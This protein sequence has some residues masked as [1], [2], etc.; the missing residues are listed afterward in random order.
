MV[1][2]SGRM[3]ARHQQT[4]LNVVSR[5]SCRKYY[6]IYEHVHSIIWSQYIFV[7][8]RCILESLAFIYFSNNG[9]KHWPISTRFGSLIM[10][11]DGRQQPESSSSLRDWEWFR[12]GRVI[13]IVQL[14]AERESVYDVIIHPS[15]TIDQKK[16]IK[17]L[18]AEYWDIFSDVP[19]MT[20]LCDYKQRR[21]GSKGTNHAWVISIGIMIQEVVGI[22]ERFRHPMPLC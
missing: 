5:K 21:D 8:L 2:E 4:I 1:L 20:K 12:R 17:K 14:E 22:M 18:L 3:T 10:S 6:F 11:D 15:L 16:Q 7:Y 19:K 13:D 9:V